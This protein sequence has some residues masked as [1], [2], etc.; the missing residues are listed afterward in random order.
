MTDANKLLKHQI[1]EQPEISLDRSDVAERGVVDWRT[2]M[3]ILRVVFALK[4]GKMSEDR[5][6]LTRR[7][8]R[9]WKPIANMLSDAQCT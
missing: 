4:K 8:E 3:A 6:K 9:E 2:L 5:V 1:E 7:K